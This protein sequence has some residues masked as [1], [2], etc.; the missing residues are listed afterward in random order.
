MKFHRS[1]RVIDTTK[2]VRSSKYFGVFIFHITLFRRI[3]FVL[4]GLQVIIFSV[5]L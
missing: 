4:H 5:I 1:I 3:I 2:E